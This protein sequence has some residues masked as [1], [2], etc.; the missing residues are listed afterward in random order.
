[1]ATDGSGAKQIVN[2]FSDVEYDWSPDGKWLV[3]SY[4]DADFNRDIWIVSIDGVRPPYNLSRTPDNERNPVWSPDGK[5]IAYTGRNYTAGGRGGA[6]GD[7]K[8]TRLNSSHLG[9]SYAV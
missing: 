4:E 2:S 8:S 6:G 1:M 5:L 7:R 3:A 9:I